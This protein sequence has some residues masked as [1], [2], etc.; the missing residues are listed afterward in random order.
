MFVLSVVP[1][2]GEGSRVVYGAESGIEA[3]VEEDEEGEEAQ[4][5]ISQAFWNRSEVERSDESW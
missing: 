2:I 5:Y 1:C 4:G 3:N